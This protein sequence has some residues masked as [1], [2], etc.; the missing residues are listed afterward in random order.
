MLRVLATV[1]GAA[2]IAAAPAAAKT[3]LPGFHSPSGNIRCYSEPGPPSILRCR[4]A[5]ADYAKALSAH[6]AAPP[7]GVD[8]GGFELSATRRG[9]VTCTGG[10]LYDPAR[11]Q[12]SFVNL[13][14]GRTWR[15]GV[16]TCASR[17]TGVTCRSRA[18]HGLFVSRESWRAW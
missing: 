13:P 11:E 10:V 17:R 14:Y 8:W 3:K 16:F 9:W 7:I 6:C 5:R 1:I 12:P 18:G 4:I 15:H 2:A